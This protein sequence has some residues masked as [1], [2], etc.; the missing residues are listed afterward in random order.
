M[1]KNKQRLRHALHN[2][3]VCN[4]IELNQEFADWV[5]TTSFYS[6]LHFVS[7]KI[8]PFEVKSIQGKS[9]TIEN[10]DQ[11]S[12]YNNTKSKSKHQLLAD[13]VSKKCP[14]I[15]EDYDW[16]LDM[17]MNARYSYYQQDKEIAQKAKRLMTLI[18]NEC[19]SGIEISDL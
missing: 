4:Y 3:S 14:K 9:T 6:C 16:L 18:K 1:K 13:L 10:I 19:A 15:S 12:N 8:F 2:E 7:Y 5:I 11:F 17:S